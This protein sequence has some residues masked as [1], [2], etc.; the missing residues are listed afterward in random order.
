MDERQFDIRGYSNPTSLINECAYPID[1]RLTYL[2]PQ[3]E[4]KLKIDIGS[5][6][7]G[8]TSTISTQN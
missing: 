6:R 2:G 3:S 1:K 8:V 7:D 5:A 4:H